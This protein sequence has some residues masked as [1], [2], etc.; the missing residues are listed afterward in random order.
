MHSLCVLLPGVSA[1]SKKQ[2]SALLDR[3]TMC[4]K[5]AWIAWIAWLEAQRFANSA[6]N[7]AMLTDSFSPGIGEVFAPLLQARPLLPVVQTHDYVY[8]KP[9]AG[10]PGAWRC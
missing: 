1:P 6:P 7:D 3:F 9:T 4:F 8:G 2:K 5:I 10:G